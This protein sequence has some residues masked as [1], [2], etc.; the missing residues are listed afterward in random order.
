[1]NR[2]RLFV[3]CGLPGSGKTT[4]A[5]NLESRFGA[6]RFCPDDWLFDLGLDLYDEDRRSKI[7]ALQW[8]L[9]QTF[10]N[11][12]VS[13]VIEWGTWSR[14]ERDILRLGARV[15]GADVEL[16]FLSAPV[17]VLY[18]RIRRRGLEDPPINRQD[19]LRWAEI[20]QEPT[21]EEM[22]LFDPPLD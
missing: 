2:P 15:V 9:G 21:E 1:M 20:F 17:D 4:R 13:V 5:K 7:E 16:H 19:L 12:G 18:E 3:V 22:K 11:K 6:V 10:L 8:K 14:A